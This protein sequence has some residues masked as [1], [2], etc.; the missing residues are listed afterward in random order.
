MRTY[1][2]LTLLTHTLPIYLLN[3]KFNHNLTK[4]WLF[5]S[6]WLILTFLAMFDY[7]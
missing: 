7:F 1:I 5:W 6:S 2:Y 4:Y 3:T